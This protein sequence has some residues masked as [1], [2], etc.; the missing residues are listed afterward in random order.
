MPCSKQTVAHLLDVL[1]K[2]NVITQN[3]VFTPNTTDLK[4]LVENVIKL[5]LN[6]CFPKIIN[7]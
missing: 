2:N 5:T 1:W 3:N 7:N 6:Q 4:N